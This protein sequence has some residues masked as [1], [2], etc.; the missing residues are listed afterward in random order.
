MLEAES[1]G[2]MALLTHRA[3]AGVPVLWGFAGRRRQRPGLG[4]LSV[5]EKVL[6]ETASCC[7]G[8]SEMSFKPLQKPHVGNGN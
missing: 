3:R 7:A 8:S 1:C 5:P 4:V 6:R 2:E